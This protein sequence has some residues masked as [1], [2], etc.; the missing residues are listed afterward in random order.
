MTEFY[1]K[2]KFENGGRRDGEKPLSHAG[3]TLPGTDIL[4]LMGTE[5]Q[6]LPATRKRAKVETIAPD[7]KRLPRR[8]E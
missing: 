4:P 6:L 8:T 3:A 2:V 5:P 1:Q 7:V